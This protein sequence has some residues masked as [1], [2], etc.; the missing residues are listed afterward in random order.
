MSLKTRRYKG[1]GIEKDILS[2]FDRYTGNSKIKE[3]F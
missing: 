1:G 3:R 2:I